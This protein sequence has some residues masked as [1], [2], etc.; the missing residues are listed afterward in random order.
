MWLSLSEAD[1]KT[2]FTVNVQKLTNRAIT[3]IYRLTTTYAEILQM[4]RKGRLSDNG[5]HNITKEKK[6][7]QSLNGKFKKSI[8]IYSSLTMAQWSEQQ[9]K[10]L[11]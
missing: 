5:Q 8:T 9:F 10:I 3:V 11:P 2:C 1:S 6:E 7:F 4:F